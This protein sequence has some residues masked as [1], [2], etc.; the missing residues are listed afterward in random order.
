[1]SSTAMPHAHE[2][3][4]EVLARLGTNGMAWAEEFRKKAL[5]AS[6]SSVD[7]LLDLGWLVGWFANAIEAGYSAGREAEK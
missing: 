3:D 4:V 1:M 7:E 5:K 6:A 2:T